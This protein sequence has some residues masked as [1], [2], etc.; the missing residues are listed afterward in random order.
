MKKQKQLE[1]FDQAKCN[2]RNEYGGTLTL[3][4]RKTAR[5]FNCKSSIH[6]VLRSTEAR[7]SKS[8]LTPA[9][10]IKVETL[11]KKLSTRWSISIYEKA[12]SGN[13]IHLLVRAKQKIQLQ[14]FLRVLAG[15]IAM[16]V[17]G[18]K[19]GS[20]NERKFWDLLAY[21]R[22]VSWGREFLKVKKYV[23]QN[24]LEAHEVFSRTEPMS[25]Y[26]LDEWYQRLRV[27]TVSPGTVKQ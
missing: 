18:R 13:H 8:F 23:F 3:G 1:F 7:G 15:Q 4:K 20:P 22:L 21:S 10:K 16:Q 2:N 27:P 25:S 5:P 11:L 26:A 19:K 9:N 12:I 6:L 24:F 17:G 14:N